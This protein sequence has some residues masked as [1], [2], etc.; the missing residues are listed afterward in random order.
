MTND[1]VSQKIPDDARGGSREQ[2]R[3]ITPELLRSWTLPEPSGTKY[4]R[5]QV[6]VVGGDRATPG[7][8]MLAGLSSL[9]M[10][11][12]RLSLAVAASIAAQVAVAVPES[13]ATS[14]ADDSEGAITG[15]QVEQHLTK[16]LER[17]DCVLVGPGLG[18]PDGAG[19][20]LSEIVRLLPDDVPIVLDAFGATVLPDLSTAE[21]DRLSGRLALT[22]NRGE[23]AHLL[24]ED[25][26][27]E[28]R[29]A[30]GIIDAAGLYGAAVGCDTWITDG[31]G[32]WQVTTGDT[33]L[34]TSGSGDVVA[35]A[36]AGLLSRGAGLVQSLVWGKYVHAAAGDALAAQFGRVGYLASE[37]PPQLPLVMRTLRGD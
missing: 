8:A 13:G 28:D 34:G 5:G 11:A 30:E 15:E 17:A 23:L 1:A 7:A 2:P 18:N 35:G 6:L 33:G 24:D 3:L 22:P 37:I 19:R 14:L 25:E 29:V 10:G 9:R 36:V 4:S 20:L 16:D 31:D 26:V 27:D 21:R 32:L 12:G